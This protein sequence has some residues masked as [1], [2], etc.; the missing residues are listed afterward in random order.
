MPFIKPPG[1]VPYID[2]SILSDFT[3]KAINCRPE[4]P[5]IKRCKNGVRF[6]SEM[7]NTINSV[8]T[9][10][11]STTNQKILYLN[12]EEYEAM[13]SKSANIKLKAKS[14]TQRTSNTFDE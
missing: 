6:T 1:I 13:E 3:Y 9:E 2:K 5:W 14:A 7:Q 8:E 12:K 10:Y 4:A 11:D